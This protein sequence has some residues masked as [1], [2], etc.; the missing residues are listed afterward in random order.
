MFHSKTIVAAAFAGAIFCNVGVALATEP[1]A[2]AAFDQIVD[3]QQSYLFTSTLDHN[4]SGLN[5]NTDVNLVRNFAT[6]TATQATTVENDF[7]SFM[8]SILGTTS[9]DP[10]WN[11]LADFNSNGVIDSDDIAIM[12]NAF[13]VRRFGYIL[14]N[15]I[16]G[17]GSGTASTLQT[18]TLV[19][20]KADA[21]DRNTDVTFSGATFKMSPT[22]P[23]YLQNFSLLADTN[24]DGTVD[25]TLQSGVAQLSGGLVTF[26]VFTGALVLRSSNKIFEVRADV[27][28]G[29]PAGGVNVHMDFATA[30]PNYVIAEKAVNGATLTGIITNTFALGQIHVN[31]IISKI[32]HLVP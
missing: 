8:T 18:I 26:R 19:R 24:G 12:H 22:S 15:Q 23:V 10:T 25:T 6:D 13:K 32:W 5:T 14:I 16:D 21:N 7:D 3:L 11:A 1:T 30:Q 2:E 9:S 31:T 28:T 29:V 17:G 20:F 4:G 27:K